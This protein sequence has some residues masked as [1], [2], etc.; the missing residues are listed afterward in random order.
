MKKQGLR[1]NVRKVIVARNVIDKMR[2]DVGK[3]PFAIEHLNAM[4]VELANMANK[5]HPHLLF[6]LITRT[7]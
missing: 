1:R 2:K 7:I 6:H 5:T 3:N 4:G